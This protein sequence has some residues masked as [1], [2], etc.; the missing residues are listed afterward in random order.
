MD[1]LETRLEGAEA[2]REPEGQ[3]GE[4]PAEARMPA[5][6]ATGRAWGGGS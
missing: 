5:E 1:E 6:I 4:Q 3:P 2:P